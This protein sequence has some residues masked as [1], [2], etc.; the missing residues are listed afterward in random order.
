MLKTDFFTVHNLQ[1]GEGTLSCTITFNKAHK[2]FEGHFPQQP[3]VPGVCTIQ[4]AKELLEQQLNKKLF[5]RSTGQVKFLQL[6]TPDINPDV[7][8]NW[9][10]NEKNYIVNASLKKDADLFK[11]TATFEPYDK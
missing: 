2:I 10:E 1:S 5:L 9:K 7:F 3:V 4:I 8:I 11:L 6:I